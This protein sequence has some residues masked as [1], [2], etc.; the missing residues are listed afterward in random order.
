MVYNAYK[1]YS[2]KK[3]GVDAD[4]VSIVIVTFLA[5]LIVKFLL[6]LA[7]WAIICALMGWTFEFVHVLC[8]FILGF[9]LSG[10]NVNTTTYKD[11]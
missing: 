2:I 11:R 5:V 3:S 10:I 8:L 6:C 4:W 9:I 1:D 7:G